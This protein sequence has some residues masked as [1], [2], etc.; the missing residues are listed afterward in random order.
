MHLL[1]DRVNSLALPMTI[2][3][4]KKSRELRAQGKDIISL[5]LGEPDFDTPDYVKEAGIQ[6]I[7]DNFSHYMP[8]PGYQDLRE[9]IAA[10]F[11]RDNG[12]DYDVNEIVVST[13]AKQTIANLMLAMVNP[14]DE[15]LI[16]APYWVTYKDLAEFAGGVVVSPKSDLSLDFKLTPQQLEDSISEKTRFMIFSTPNNPSGAMYSRE[17]LEGLAEV[18]R[19]HPNVFVACDEI[20]E[21]IRYDEAPHASLAAIDGMRDQVATIN[22]LSKG[23]AMT[24]Y[25]LGYMGAPAAVAKACEKIQSQ[26]TS[27]TGSISQR[28]A[29]AA[30]TEGPEPVQYM[31]DAFTSRRTLLMDALRG[32]THLNYQ[33]PE[34]AFYLFVDASAYLGGDLPDSIALSMRILDAG[35]ATVPGDAF[36]LPGYI[37]MSYAAS[38][39]DLREAARRIVNC[40]NAIKA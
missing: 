36:G 33:S 10:K 28:A 8:V 24:G 25:R 12:L 13:G 29:I 20:Y 34:G 2:E 37:R 3:M 5:S 30:M 38:E 11:K 16:P 4:S 32:A 39:D 14:G 9:A 26:F 18:L 35:V 15:V 21:Y 40:L 27:G 7:K 19:R 23:F 31:L 6:G 1:S 22:G 17:E